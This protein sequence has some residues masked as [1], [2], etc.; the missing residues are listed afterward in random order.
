MRSI[1]FGFAKYEKYS[2]NEGD[3]SA[4]RIY[5]N[6]VNENYINELDEIEWKISSYNNDGSCY[7]KIIMDGEYLTNNMYCGITGGNVRPE[8]LFI[9][10]IV[11]H[12]SATKTKLTQVIK[13]A[14][15][16]PYTILTDKYMPGKR[17]LTLGGDIDYKMNQFTCI[18]LEK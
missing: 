2:E 12:Y 13:R 1:D 3:E 16:K 4:D 14:D 15:I 7:S 5:E 10:R 18:M 6:V 11:S 9:R 8:E 17:F